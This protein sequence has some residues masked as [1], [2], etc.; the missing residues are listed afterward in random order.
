MTKKH[1]LWLIPLILLLLLIPFIVPTSLPDAEAEEA[2]IPE[3]APVELANPDPGPVPTKEEDW[4]KTTREKVT[5]SPK[6]KCYLRDRDGNLCGYLDGTISVKIDIRTI[7]GTRVFFTWIQIADPS[8]FRAQFSSPYPSTS[9]T[10]C[11]KLAGRENSVLAINGDSCLGIKAGVVYRN[12]TEYRTVT[13]EQYD[14]LIVD[15]NGDFHILRNPSLD[16]IA[17]YEGNILHSFVFGPAL[18]VDGVAEDLRANRNFG[19][20]ITL[21]K[22]AQRQVLCQM[23]TLSY[24][25]ITTEGPEQSKDGGFTLYDLQEIV[26]E[27]GCVNA[28]NLDGGCTTWLVLGTDRINNHNGRSLRGI[29]DFIYFVTAEQ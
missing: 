20:G 7:Q 18:V 17:A 12:G 22:K 23:D 21:R 2:E 28:Y 4:K 6:G 26:F 9:E 19:P 5:T 25:I 14:Q 3:Y 29:T 16:E 1:L 8:Q 24:L 15:K 10:N 13:G 27:T 11:D